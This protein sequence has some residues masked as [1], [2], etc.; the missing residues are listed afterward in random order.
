[1]PDE[2][3][4]P[5]PLWE[6]MSIKDTLLWGTAQ[7]RAAAMLSPAL[8][9]AVLLTEVLG[10]DRAKLLLE[11]KRRLNE[12]TW[13]SYDRALKRRIA[14][15]CVAYIVGHKEFWGLD[16]AVTSDVLVP[17]PDTETLVEAALATIARGEGDQSLL[18]V[19]T[20]SGAVAIA[21][22]HD[23]PELDVHASDISEPALQVAREN[24]ARLLPDA[25]AISF[26][27]SDLLDKVARRFTLITA[28]PPYVP[29][30]VIDTLAP[31]VRNEPRLALDGG[32]DGLAL[33]R[34]LVRDAGAHLDPGG[35]LLLE[36]AP[37]LMDEIASLLEAADFRE[38]QCH[39]DATGR[40][41]VI[42]G[43]LDAI[44]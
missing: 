24:A 25:T 21:L 2:A 3:P 10:V 13:R 8:D 28:N 30:D 41:R 16:F 17:R 15:E 20:G 27:R 44:L 33:I 34:R 19:C 11:E 31:E 7:L 5:V 35:T 40:L 1:M 6:K 36:A 14:G 12:D 18:D 38:I 23:V 37:D 43:R 29:S 42:E 4:V 26:T 32:A 9:A 22:K 39:I